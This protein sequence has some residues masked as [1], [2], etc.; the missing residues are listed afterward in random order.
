MAK[1]AWRLVFAEGL[2]GNYISGEAVWTFRRYSPT[3]HEFTKG[4]IIEGHFKDG[5]M[6]LLE[7]LEDT[8]LKPFIEITKREYTAWGAKS[9]ADM[10]RQMRVHYPDLSHED[11]A[12]LINVRLAR[13]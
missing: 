13:I 5:I 3:S 9:H 4:Q 10:M 11:T 7:V 1:K 2:I 6:L 12:A 8:R